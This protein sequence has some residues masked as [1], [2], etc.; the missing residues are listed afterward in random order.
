MRV[1]TGDSS[2][3]T[4]ITL[5]TQAL[6][7]LVAAHSIAATRT[8][9]SGGGVVSEDSSVNLDLDFDLHLNFES[10]LLIYSISL[11]GMPSHNVLTGCVA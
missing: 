8:V 9:P 11:E 1:L 7:C 2:W 4:I 10:G 5:L 6:G 3:D